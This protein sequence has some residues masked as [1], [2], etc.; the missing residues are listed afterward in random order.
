MTSL[1]RGTSSL[2]GIGFTSSEATRPWI[3]LCTAR[4]G[5]MA[6]RSNSRSSSSEESLTPCPGQAIRVLRGLTL[7]IPWL[8]H[9][10]MCAWRPATVCLWSRIVLVV[11]PCSVRQEAASASCRARTRGTRRLANLG[12][13]I[14]LAAGRVHWPKRLNSSWIGAMTRRA[15]GSPPVNI[16]TPTTPRA[17]T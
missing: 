11:L 16:R 5:Q 4:P 1:V 13:W 6:V 10:K 7:R 15:N 14:S 8:F 2:Q 9:D 17:R 12:R 3:G